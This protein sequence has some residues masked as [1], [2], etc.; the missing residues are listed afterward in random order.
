[1][2]LVNNHQKFL[3]TIQKFLTC[4]VLYPIHSQ[5]I[6]FSHAQGH[7]VKVNVIILTLEGEKKDENKY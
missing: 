7:V 3:E 4:R 6:Q 5:F 2:S 1:M